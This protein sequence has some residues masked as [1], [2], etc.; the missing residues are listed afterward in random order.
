MQDKNLNWIQVLNEHAEWSDHSGLKHWFDSLV[1]RRTNPSAEAMAVFDQSLSEMR[2]IVY[3][4]HFG[5]N[6]E[7]SWLKKQLVPIRFALHQAED[8]FPP[9][10]L[11]IFRACAQ[12]HDDSALLLSLKDTLVHQCAQFVGEVLSAGEKSNVCRCEGLYRDQKIASVSFLR[13]IPE[14]EELRWRREIAVLVEKELESEAQIQR[15]ADLFVGNSRSR[16][17]SDA[18]R[19]STFQ[20][21]KQ[22][23]DPDYLAEK[24]RRYRNKKS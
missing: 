4:L 18:C 16:F 6:P 13:S 21:I 3:D 11:P 8:E 15:C 23:K 10:P 5:R 12:G 7:L 14:E 2:R 20:I 19:F 1:D 9:S 24:Q 17:C 22:L